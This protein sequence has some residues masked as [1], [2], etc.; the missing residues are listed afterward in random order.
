V[1]I[2]LESVEPTLAQLAEQYMASS[3][4]AALRPNTKRE[5]CRVLRVEVLPRI[6]HLPA[7]Q[8]RRKD[9]ALLLLAPLEGRPGIARNAYCATSA[10]YRWAMKRGLVEANP[11][12]SIAPPKSKPATVCSR[13][14]RYA[15]SGT[16]P[17]TWA[18]TAASSACF[19]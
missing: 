19:C 3:A 1:T 8:V 6:G 9:V 5:N 11:A 14:M 12:T 10:V 17:R 18:T 4:L 2:T 16:R 13:T 15:C 7:E